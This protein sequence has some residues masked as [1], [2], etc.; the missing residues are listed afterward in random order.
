MSTMPQIKDI[1]ANAPAILSM[2]DFTEGNRYADY[3]SGDKVASYG[4]A[5]L[6]AGGVLAKSGFFKVIL[7]FLAKFWKLFAL[8]AVA[9]GSSVKKI[10]GGRGRQQ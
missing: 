10:F 3:K 5:A 6:I 9:I 4:I 8:G 7:I 1:E 2:V